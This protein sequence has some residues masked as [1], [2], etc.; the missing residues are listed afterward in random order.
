GQP[1]TRRRKSHILGAKIMVNRTVQTNVWQWFQ[2]CRKYPGSGASGTAPQRTHAGL[3]A[4]QSL[5]LG[6]RPQCVRNGTDGAIGIGGASW[7]WA[8]AWAKFV[9]SCFAPGPGGTRTK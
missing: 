9:A 3:R 8:G 5:A 6:E 2:H 4:L 1:A 7:G